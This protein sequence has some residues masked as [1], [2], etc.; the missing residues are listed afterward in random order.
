MSVVRVRVNV[1]PV[2]SAN[3]DG[4]MVTALLAPGP[5]N[6]GA[7][8]LAVGRGAPVEQHVRA[9][10][11]IS[12]IGAVVVRAIGLIVSVITVTIIGLLIDFRAILSCR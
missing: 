5:L 11:V 9:V 1:E 10:L 8:T 7:E 2:D 3:P 6:V 12:G 4:L